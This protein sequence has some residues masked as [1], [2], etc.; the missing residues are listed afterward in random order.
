M[1][2]DVYC[3][4]HFTSSTCEGNG[5]KKVFQLEI[6]P[7]QNN[8]M[9]VTSFRCAKCAD[10]KERKTCEKP[11]KSH[12]T[13]THPITFIV[14]NSITEITRK[15]TKRFSLFF[16]RSNSVR[17]TSIRLS[18]SDFAIHEKV[19]ANE[20]REKRKERKITT[21]EIAVERLNVWIWI[22]ERIEQIQIAS[23]SIV[24]GFQNGLVFR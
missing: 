4:W 21:N 10:E 20:W 22:R 6:S 2:A 9:F 13:H 8:R 3:V 17:A 23:E 7:S 5:V 24:M 16:N 19:D 15:K 18:F 12:H 1:R 14:Y 11:N